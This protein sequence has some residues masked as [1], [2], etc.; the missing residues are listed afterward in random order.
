MLMSM[1]DPDPITPMTALTLN[2]DGQLTYMGED[3]CRRVILG[4]S[5]LLRRLEQL[6]HKAEEN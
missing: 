1:V 6:R 2:Q 3:G 5:G 4:D